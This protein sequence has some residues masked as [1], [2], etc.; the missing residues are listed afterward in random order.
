MTSTSIKTITA[1]AQQG[2]TELRIAINQFANANE[3]DMVEHWHEIAAIMQ[4]IQFDL[5]DLREDKI[6]QLNEEVA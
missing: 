1:H 4:T 5:N 3:D 2:L 6:K